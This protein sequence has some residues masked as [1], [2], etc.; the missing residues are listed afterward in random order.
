MLYRIF[1]DES[2]MFCDN[3]VGFELMC[4]EFSAIRISDYQDMFF[5]SAVVAAVVVVAA[6]A[7]ACGGGEG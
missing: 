2:F 1:D 3:R 7:A 4:V 5:F 6:A